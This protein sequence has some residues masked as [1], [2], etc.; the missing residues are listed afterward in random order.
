MYV[1]AVMV[2]RRTYVTVVQLGIVHVLAW[3][4]KVMSENLVAIKSRRVGNAT[5]A[6]M[7]KRRKRQQSGT[8]TYARVQDAFNRTAANIAGHVEH[9]LRI[10]QVLQGTADP[11]TSN[12][13]VPVEW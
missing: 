8:G 2:P 4:A 3:I 5:R 1:L 10:T 13:N 9:L 7:R 6:R 12:G 11:A